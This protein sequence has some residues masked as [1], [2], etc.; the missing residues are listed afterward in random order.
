MKLTKLKILAAAATLV[1]GI[2][3]ARA[4]IGVTTN[5]SRLNV[6]GM[7][8]TNVST[9]IVKGNTYIY[10][11]GKTKFGNKQLLE[12]FGNWDG[13]TWPTG[14][15]LV[16]G[17]DWSGDVLVVDKTGTNVLFDATS[18]G[19]GAYFDLYGDEYSGAY[20]ERYV[21]AVPG[22]DAYTYY[23]GSYF[24]LYDDNT[25]LPY[26]YFWNYGSSTERFRIAWDASDN[27]TKWSD[28]QTMMFPAQ[29]DQSFMNNSDTTVSAR[30]SS[31][32]KGN[33]DNS[34]LY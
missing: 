6:T 1:L 22:S 26:T 7:I 4:T 21:D 5:Y 8:I 10:R 20:S 19:T 34:Y 25:Y 15:K 32:G 16:L 28:H 13:T 27:Y 17:W 23:N 33:G 3:S 11:V 2:S 18:N 14:A 29:A 12:L 9:T 30:A 31:N 24:E